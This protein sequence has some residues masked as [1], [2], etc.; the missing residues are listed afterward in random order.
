MEKGGDK[1]SGF[2]PKVERIFGMVNIYA[3][4][5]AYSV[6]EE[7]L[8][9]AFEAYGAVE[10]VSVISDRLT[11][12]SRGFGFVEMPNDEEARTAISSLHD[13]DLKGRK[14]L[15]REARPKAETGGGG[16]GS[17]RHERQD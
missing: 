9:G 16:Y 6:T 7:D 5:L 15:I 8:R 14:M 11:G 2:I 10:R 13:V 3:G 12:R 17:P 1:E 4:N